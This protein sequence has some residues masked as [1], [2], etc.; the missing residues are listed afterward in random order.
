MDFSK[1]RFRLTFLYTVI[2]ASLAVITV[3]VLFISIWFSIE[4]TNSRSLRTFAV[5]LGSAYELNQKFN[6]SENLNTILTALSEEDITYTLYNDQ[7]DQMLK[8]DNYP[9]DNETSFYLIQKFFS[10]RHNDGEIVDFDRGRDSFKICTDAYITDSGNL[11]MIQLIKNMSNQRALLQSPLIVAII[12]IVLGIIISILLGNFLARRSLRPIIDNYNRQQTFIANASHELRT[13]LAVILSNLEAGQLDPGE[14]KWINNA[15]VEVKFAR[16]VIEDLLFLS[17]ADMGESEIQL[18]PVDL[19]YLVLETSERLNL[20][21]Q[22][23]NIRIITDVSDYDLFVMGDLKWITELLTILIDNAIKYSESGEDIE[24]ILTH[25]ES[26]VTLKVID[27]G[28]GIAKEDQDKIFDR[29]YRVDKTRSRAEGGTG[30][31]LSI[32]SL[33]C[34]RLNISLSV[35]SELG[36]GSSFILVFNRVRKIEER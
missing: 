24:I 2:L 3:I 34:K 12:V 25:T 15:L 17:R 28:I 35:K 31:G 13:P 5:Q 32:A 7:L 9:I 8:S 18:E 33:I 21:A 36:E 11:V 29:F 4:T 23:K 30:L 19:S 26:T 10:S 6:N 27:H 1:V 16:N 14:S 20:I 22:K